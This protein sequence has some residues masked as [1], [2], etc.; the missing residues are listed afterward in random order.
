MKQ[1]IQVMEVSIAKAS[2][3][4]LPQNSGSAL[5]AEQT[6]GRPGMPHRAHL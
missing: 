5:N 4:S 2:K 6:S 1:N 3:R